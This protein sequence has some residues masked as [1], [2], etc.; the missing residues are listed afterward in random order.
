[1]T[2]IDDCSA[3]YDAKLHMG[4]LENI[5]R[6][7]GLVASSHQVIETWSDSRAKQAAGL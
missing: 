2:M 7:F 4:T 1:V 6:H 5:R 3:A